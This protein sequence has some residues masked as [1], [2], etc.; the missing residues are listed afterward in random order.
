MIGLAERAEAYME[1][2]QQKMQQRSGET[3]TGLE[4]RASKRQRINEAKQEY[5]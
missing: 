4:N 3:H 1:Q 5:A 2:E